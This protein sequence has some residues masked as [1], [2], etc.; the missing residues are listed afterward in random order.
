MSEQIHVFDEYLSAEQCA[1]CI[2]LYRAH[3]KS[4]QADGFWCDRTVYLD[5]GAWPH[6]L[7]CDLEAHI[8]REVGIEV[9]TDVPVLV[10]WTHGMEMPPHT[11]FGTHGEFPTRHWSALIY[12]NDDF[13]GGV[14]FFPDLDLGVEPERGSLIV[15]AGGEHRHGVSKLVGGP[16]FTFTN[17]FRPR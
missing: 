16:R 10:E 3:P 14:T 5:D 2:G 12:L 9:V 13:D 15:F 1:H 7:T 17:F 8:G 4:H 11:D 6:Y